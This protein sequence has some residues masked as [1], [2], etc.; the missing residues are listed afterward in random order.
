MFDNLICDY[1]Y[2]CLTASKCHY[3]PHQHKC[4]IREKVNKII[5]SRVRYYT[6][7]Q[8]E[9]KHN[10]DKPKKSDFRQLFLNSLRSG[11]ECSYCLKPMTLEPCC[12]NSATIDHIRA[13]SLSG[14]N[15]LGNMLLCCNDCN[16]KKAQYESN[17]INPKKE[18]VAE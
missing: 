16:S 1:N 11:F 7:K 13:R 5:T 8:K 17:M 4:Q 10:G 14:D 12:C 3:C 15:S 6:W 9:N 18:E 2:K